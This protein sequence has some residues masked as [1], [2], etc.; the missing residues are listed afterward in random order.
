MVNLRK[1]Y[2][3]NSTLKIGFILNY[4]IKPIQ[5]HSHPTTSYASVNYNDS[6]PMQN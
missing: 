4:T 2:T 3:W 5:D 1:G 6:S